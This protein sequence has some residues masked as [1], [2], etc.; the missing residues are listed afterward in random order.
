MNFS[1]IFPGVVFATIAP[2]SK[3]IVLSNGTRVI[4]KEAE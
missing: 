1:E 3:F 2:N 4:V